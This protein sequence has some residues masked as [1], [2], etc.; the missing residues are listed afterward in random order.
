MSDGLRRAL[1]L[2]LTVV[3]A[4]VGVVVLLLVLQSRDDGSLQRTPS[5]PARTAVP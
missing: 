3:V 1:S 4:V 2:L 5:A